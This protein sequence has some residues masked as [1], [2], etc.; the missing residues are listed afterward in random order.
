MDCFENDGAAYINVG[1]PIA[2]VVGLNNK[3]DDAGTPRT[4][5]LAISVQV[6]DDAAFTSNLTTLMTLGT[7]AAGAVAGTLIFGLLPP[8]A[9]YSRYMR[10][11]FRP[12]G[13]LTGGKVYAHLCKDYDKNVIFPSRINI[14]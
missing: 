1:E 13:T 2:I 4:V 3:L 9:L 11:V 6:A 10:V 12:S 8:G 7:F 5:T 14:L